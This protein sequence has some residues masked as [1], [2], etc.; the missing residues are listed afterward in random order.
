[1]VK[2]GKTKRTHSFPPQERLTHMGGGL[3]SSWIS[4]QAVW[5]GPA[6]HNEVK[7]KGKTLKEGGVAKKK[8]E[9]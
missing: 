9:S 7:G 1:M 6:E 5:V 8:G 3:R 2:R 4:K